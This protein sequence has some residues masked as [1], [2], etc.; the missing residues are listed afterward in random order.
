MRRGRPPPDSTMR[1]TNAIVALAKSNSRRTGYSLF[2]TSDRS[3]SGLRGISKRLSC[4]CLRTFLPP[5]R[6]IRLRIGSREPRGREPAMCRSHTAQWS[7]EAP[8]YLVFPSF[9][10]SWPEWSSLSLLWSWPSPSKWPVFAG[11]LVAGVFEP[12]QPGKATRA[13]TTRTALASWNMVRII[14]FLSERNKE[15][16]QRSCVASVGYRFRYSRSAISVS[17]AR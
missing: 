3:P 2:E 17:P 6:P 12:P 10:W 4:L 1:R 11:V 16:R 5:F 9:S 15:F 13:A 8:A 7:F 14:S